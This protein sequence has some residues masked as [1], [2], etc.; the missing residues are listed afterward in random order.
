VLE[1]DTERAIEG[2]KNREG[3]EGTLEKDKEIA[4]DGGRGIR[5]DKLRERERQREK[6]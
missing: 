5:R 1:T 2:V 4:K 3:E 6:E